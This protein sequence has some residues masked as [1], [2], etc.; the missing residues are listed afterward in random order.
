MNTSWTR[1]HFATWKSCELFHFAQVKELFLLLSPGSSRQSS[2]EFLQPHLTCPSTIHGRTG[3]KRNISWMNTILPRLLRILFSLFFDFRRSQYYHMKFNPSRNALVILLKILSCLSVKTHLHCFCKRH[4]EIQLCSTILWRD[5]MEV[6]L[7]AS[8]V[9]LQ[10]CLLKSLHITNCWRSCL[11]S[12][13]GILVPKLE[14]CPTLQNPFFCLRGLLYLVCIV[15]V[16]W[17]S[18][19]VSIDWDLLQLFNKLFLADLNAW[20]WSKIPHP[21]NSLSCEEHAI[22]F[23]WT[24]LEMLS[25]KS[26]LG[27]HCSISVPPFPEK[28]ISQKRFMISATDLHGLLQWDAT[29]SQLLNLPVIAHTIEVRCLLCHALV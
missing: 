10:V 15:G 22:P 26:G 14:L 21:T 20:S 19:F 13:S 11:W 16:Q 18:F 25:C 9:V 29:F 3:M 28:I 1:F 5:R 23:F 6:S 27:Q 17:R 2:C 7:D 24:N 4:Q 12:T 8:W